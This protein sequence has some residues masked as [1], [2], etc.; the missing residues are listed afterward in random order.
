MEAAQGKEVNREAKLITF[1][2]HVKADKT[3]ADLNPNEHKKKFTDQKYQVDRIRNL[4]LAKSYVYLYAGL[5]TEILN[6]QLDVE[7]LYV[8]Q[9]VPLDGIYHADGREQFTPTTPTKVTR[10][11]DEVPYNDMGNDFNDL[12]QYS[13]S[14]LGLEEQQKNETDGS[15]AHLA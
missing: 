14:P 11:L 3:T 9:R 8:N 6:F 12:V 4:T 1:T 10:F 2:I 13:D 7:Q 15:D 5:N